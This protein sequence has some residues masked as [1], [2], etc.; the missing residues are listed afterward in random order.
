[1]RIGLI[2][3]VLPEKIEFVGNASLA[4]AKVLLLSGEERMR[5]EK[6]AATIRHLSLAQDERFQEIFI[7][8]L[9]F[10]RWK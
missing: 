6:L 3:T 9:T 1:M 8:S 5:C 10:K 2:P 4:G 7:D